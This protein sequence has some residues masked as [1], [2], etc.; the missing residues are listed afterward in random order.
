[1]LATGQN[2]LPAAGIGAVADQLASQ[3]PATSL[4]LNSPASSV[5]PGEKANA[6]LP[7]VTMADGS[8]LSA[9]AV[10]VA[11]EGPAAKK[12]LGAIL[13]TAPSKDADPVGTCCL[14]FSAPKPPLPG[15]ILYLDGDGGTGI[16]NNCCFPS[17]VSQTYAP[18]GQTLV[19]VS[20]LGVLTNMS[21]EELQKQVLTELGEWFS[22]SNVSSWRHLK[23]YRIPYAQPNQAPPTDPFRKEA[24][25]NGV[26]VAGDHRTS[27]TLDAALKSGRVAAEQ[28]I[29]ELKK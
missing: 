19:S 24:L 8:V 22:A 13:E 3:I 20:T 26:W 9:K 21:D 18:Q 16:V 10:V 25:G 27:A 12:L 15:N 6:V 23:T 1:M 5:T 17:E 28:I 2:C 7:S 4:R 29:A 14:Y 11:T